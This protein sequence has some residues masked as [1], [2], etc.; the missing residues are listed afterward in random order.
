MINIAV[1]GIPYHHVELWINLLN[2]ME[3]I[4]ASLFNEKLQKIDIVYWVFGGGPAVKK[5]PL[6]WLKKNPLLIIHWIG[7]DVYLR[8][9]YKQSQFFNLNK[10]LWDRI[11]KIKESRNGVVHL[12]TAEWLVPELRKTG[13]TAEYLPISTIDTSQPINEKS[14]SEREY[15]FL[16]Y[17]P[18]NR[19][20][21]Y[22]EEKILSIAKKLPTKKFLIIRP[23][24][25][26]KEDLSSNNKLKNITYLPRK[27]FKEMNEIYLNSKCFLRCTVHDSLSLSVLEA[28][29]YKEQVFWTYDYPNVHC[30]S[31]ISNLI[32]KLDSTVSDWK[33][34][35]DGHN[36]V[37]KNFNLEKIKA[38]FQNKLDEIIVSRVLNT[39]L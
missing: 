22:G 23:D 21:F 38:D 4:N 3:G 14:C 39:A 1:G 35:I 7:S 6:F 26:E 15:D 36:F 12:T 24:I 34:N 11:L 2:S 13:I 19:G 25:L 10:A 29:Y 17:I 16:S 5:F 18:S 27:P 32:E 28:L 20:P 8:T 9:Q 30:L 37:K 33:P 31:K